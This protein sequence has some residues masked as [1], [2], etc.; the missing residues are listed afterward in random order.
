MHMF[1]LMYVSLTLSQKP[2]V[3]ETFNTGRRNFEPGTDMPVLGY[4][5]I[6]VIIIYHVI[7]R[8]HQILAIASG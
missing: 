4:A 6:N 1:Y 5:K 7:R 3:V 2:R 8:M